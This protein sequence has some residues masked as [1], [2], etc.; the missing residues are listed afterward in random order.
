M[1][2]EEAAALDDD[3]AWDAWVDAQAPPDQTRDHL[4]TE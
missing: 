4:F 1:T 2:A 3:A